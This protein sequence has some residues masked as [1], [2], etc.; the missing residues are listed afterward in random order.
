M[1]VTEAVLSAPD[2][3][4]IVEYGLNSF[5]TEPATYRVSAWLKRPAPKTRLT[6]HDM[7]VAGAMRRDLDKD[8]I[9]EAILHNIIPGEN[10]R[11]TQ[12]VW[13]GREDATHVS[14]SGICGAIAPIGE[15]RVVGRVSWS[16][17]DVAEEVEFA[18]H[19]AQS[20]RPSD[21][22]VKNL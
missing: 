12:L 17:E 10:P 3:G 4:D 15:C 6:G 21:V 1:T 13:C 20:G 18:L 7:L 2:V 11:G 9:C 16:A 14:L 8:Q 22:F 19:L 5:R